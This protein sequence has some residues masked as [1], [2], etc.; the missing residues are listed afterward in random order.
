VI[1]EDVRIR[2]RSVPPPR[3]RDI[4]RGNLIARKEEEWVVRRP[5]SPPRKT[6]EEQEIIIRRR[7]RSPSPVPEPPREPTPEPCPPPP[8]PLEPIIRP[9]IIQE[10]ITHHRHIDHGVERARSPS[11]SPSPP[12]PAPACPPAREEDLEIAI[13]RKGVRNGKA[14]EEEIIIDKEIREGGDCDLPAAPEPEPP[15]R[16]RSVSTHHRYR[17]SSR[18]SSRSSGRRSRRYDPV[19]DEA[20]YYNRK[21]TSRTYPGEAYDGVTRDWAIV[22]VPPGTERVRMDGVGGGSQEITWQRYNGERRAKFSTGERAYESE[23]GSTGSRAPPVPVPAPSPP[24][25]APAPPPAPV[26]PAATSTEIKITDT[27]IVKT[28]D[29]P[30]PCAPSA[31]P[32]ERRRDRMWTELTKDLVIREAILERGYEFEE[33]EDYFYVIEYLRYVSFPISFLLPLSP[34]RTPVC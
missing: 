32:R 26:A 19:A 30:S 12:P 9:P 14:F 33:T 24:P 4:S 23:F 7:E 6:I 29:A 1:K 31:E 28:D 17:S 27:R 11:P 18:E 10:V 3:Q 5:R 21:A 25:A 8:P 20:A 13:K 2:E 15:R 22:D 34:Q 16:Q